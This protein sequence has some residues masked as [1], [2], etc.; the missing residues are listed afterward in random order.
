METEIIVLHYTKY[1]E[2]SLV[3]H[4]L[5]K[6]F[7][8]K[9]FFVRSI[10]KKSLKGYF[11]PL[12]IIEAKV[13]KNNKSSLPTL[14]NVD[15]SYSLLGIRNS[16]YKSAIAMFMSEVLFKV[17]KDGECEAQL[18]DWA[19]RSILLLEDLKAGFSNFHIWFLLELSVVLGYAPTEK[20]LLPYIEN[21]EKGIIAFLGL[22][23]KEAM[24]FPLNGVER[25]IIARSLIKYI[26]NNSESKININSLDVLRE[27]FE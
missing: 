22:S 12:N 3:L 15:S 24:L 21:D 7:G 27:L 8:R 18:Y 1:G 17:I 19:K 13:D 2:A 4:S 10:A 6:D 16:I 25:N 23:F 5:S 20:S 14:K 11:S 26:E 9:S